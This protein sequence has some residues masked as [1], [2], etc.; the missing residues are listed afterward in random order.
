[1]KISLGLINREAV[2][3]PHSTGPTDALNENVTLHKKQGQWLLPLLEGRGEESML[4]AGWD[5]CLPRAV[6]VALAQ[7]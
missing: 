6:P 1:M 5:G 3:K 7:G 2:D 4:S